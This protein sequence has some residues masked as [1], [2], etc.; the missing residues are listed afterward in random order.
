MNPSPSDAL[1]SPLP[2]GQCFTLAT[3]MEATAPKPGNI[4][5]GADFEDTSYPDFLVAATVVGP[6]MELA[7]ELPLG[8]TVLSA[9]KAT[10]AAVATNTNLGTVLLVA[11]M[12]KVPRTKALERGIGDVLEKLTP[13]DARDVYQ[14]IRL[15]RPGGLGKVESAD[16]AGEPPEDLIGA[17]QMA[18]DHDMVARQ[19]ACKFE[20]VFTTVVPWLVRALDAGM[21]LADAIVHVY[22]ELMSEFPDS[23]IARR[24]GAKVAQQAS[25]MA[26]H[27]LASGRP[28]DEDYLGALSDLDFWLRADGHMRNPGTTADLVAAGLFVALRDEIIKP[29]FRLVH[30]S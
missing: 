5:R 19:Y 14:A 28:G 26:A 10:R 12:A 23:L 17:M 3:I 24:R 22:L 16:V 27:V 15:A 18:A 21:L 25:D 2:V 9:V 7:V 20:D 29:P 30:P 1:L 13:Q 4:H 6:I 11:P 8:H